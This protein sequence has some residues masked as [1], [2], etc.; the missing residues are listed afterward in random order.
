MRRGV[1]VLVMASIL[2]WPCAAAFAGID[3]V[4]NGSFEIGLT[5]W[6]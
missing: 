1:F 5:S 4:V 2:A 6:S 3:L